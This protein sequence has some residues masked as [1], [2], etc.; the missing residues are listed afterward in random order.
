M[1]CAAG[2]RVNNSDLTIG[3]LQST[4]DVKGPP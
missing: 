3:F 4:F 1:P 2:Y